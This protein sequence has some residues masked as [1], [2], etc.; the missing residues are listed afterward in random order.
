M[1]TVTP[2]LYE[3]DAI[4]GPGLE[5]PAAPASRPL[6]EVAT[7][8]AGE[9]TLPGRRARVVLSSGE[10]FVVRLTN[11]DYVRYD[12]E[13]QRRKLPEGQ[14][15]PFVFATFLAWSAALRDGQTDLTWPAWMDNVEDLEN[16]KGDEED[17]ARPTR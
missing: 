17:A 9:R 6:V 16:L 3:T 10:E 8:D 7:E 15:A 12:L 1:T 2:D 4:S 13:R 5:P 14:G 11:R